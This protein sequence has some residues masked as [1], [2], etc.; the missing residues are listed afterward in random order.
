MHVQMH[1]LLPS[2]PL[3]HSFSLSVSRSFFLSLFL[4]NMSQINCLLSG[5]L[6]RYQV[7]AFKKAETDIAITMS[8]TCPTLPCLKHVLT[9][10]INKNNIVQFTQ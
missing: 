2:P 5:L 9:T 3:P 10:V 4:L 7:I 1:T 6:L 8:K